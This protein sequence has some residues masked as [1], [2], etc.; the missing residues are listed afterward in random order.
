[1]P[2]YLIRTAG[3]SPAEA[4]AANLVGV[5]T[6]A[7]TAPLGGYLI[8]R[9][10]P[11][12]VAIV[13]MAG[14]AVTALP[15]FLIIAAYRTPTAAVLGQ[16]LCSFFLGAAFSVGAVLAMTLFPTGIR[17]TAFAMP[18]SIGTAL[19]GSTAPYVSTW[20]TV[21]TDQPLAPGFYLFTAAVAGTLAAAI[22]LRRRDIAAPA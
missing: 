2:S 14:V 9:F 16:V 20:L 1:M 21:T 3:L 5:L 19:F 22:G 12:R 15:G 18:I 11:R 6:S 17:F 4:Y 7:A 10:P 13:V 8:D